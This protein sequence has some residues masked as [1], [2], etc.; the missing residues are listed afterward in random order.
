MGTVA[1]AKPCWNDANGQLDIFGVLILIN[2]QESVERHREIRLHQRRQ[3]PP[4]ASSQKPQ[5]R[6]GKVAI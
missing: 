2:M 3:V 1:G 6:S 4:G 5:S